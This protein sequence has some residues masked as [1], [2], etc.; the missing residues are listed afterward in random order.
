MVEAL[1][2]G[3]NHKSTVRLIWAETGLCTMNIA[4]SEIFF[5]AIHS[6]FEIQLT[7]RSEKRMKAEHHFFFLISSDSF[8]FIITITNWVLSTIQYYS[9]HF[10]CSSSIVTT[11]VYSRNY[12]ILI[13]QMTKLR[14]K[15]GKQP[16]QVSTTSKF[17][18]GCLI[19]EFIS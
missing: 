8:S 3:M 5:K 2:P 15:E 11:S 7:P 16:V 17:S 9:K 19:P 6:W 12:F 1:W 4:L 18:P 13:L 14:E 10:I